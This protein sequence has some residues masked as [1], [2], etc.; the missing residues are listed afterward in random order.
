M[1]VVAIMIEDYAPESPHHPLS[2]VALQFLVLLYDSIQ[3][4]PSQIEYFN[5]ATVTVNGKLSLC[6]ISRFN[7]LVHMC[8]YNI[9]V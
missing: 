3:S 7:K 5:D 8:I 9:V 2:S 6:F 4:C 1:K